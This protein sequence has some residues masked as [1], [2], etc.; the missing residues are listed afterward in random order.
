M[1]LLLRWKAA[2]GDVVIPKGEYSVSVS[3]DMGFITLHGHG[4][5]YRIHAQKRPTRTKVKQV[6]LQFQPSLGAATWILSVCTPPNVEWFC[7]LRMVNQEEESQ[8]AK[9][10]ERLRLLRLGR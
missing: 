8:K 4:T 1:N 7:H 6:R 10:K 9:E 3:R 5:D 2:S